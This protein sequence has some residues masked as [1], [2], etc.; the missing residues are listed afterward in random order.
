MYGIVNLAASI[1]GIYVTWQGSNFKLL[2]DDIEMSK[3]VGLYII[4]KETVVIYIYIHIYIC[5]CDI[6]CVFVCCDK[7]TK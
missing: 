3:H 7:N 4:Q 1:L 5:C 2:E 6:N